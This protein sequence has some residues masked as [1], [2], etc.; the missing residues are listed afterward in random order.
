MFWNGLSNNIL[1]EMRK[2]NRKSL[3]GVVAILTL[4]VAGVA[5]AA[6]VQVDDFNTGSLGEITVSAGTTGATEDAVGSALGDERDIVVT[7][8]SG[9][10]SVSMAVNFLNSAWLAY[11]SGSNVTGKGFVIWDGDDNDAFTS[12]HTMNVD[13]EGGGTN[14]GFHIEV[15]DN[16]RPVRVVIRVYSS[17]TEWSEA[18]FITPGNILFPNHV[19]FFLPFSNF[20]QGAG[21]AAE[22]VFTG[23]SA[24]ELELD[25]TVSTSADISM[26]FLD[27][28]NFRDYGDLPDTFG[29]ATD[30]SHIANGL[31]LGTQVD[32]EA[33]KPA[34]PGT[35]ANV[36]D[37]T[38]ADDEDGV[39][40]TPGVNW[41]VGPGG[42][43]INFSVNGCT[44]APCYLNA[45]MDSNQNNAFDAGEEL[46]IDF[47]VGNSNYT[48]VPVTVPG[49]TTFN[50]AY[51]VRFRICNSPTD[52][53]DQISDVTGGEVEDYYW[54]FGP[55]A[56]TL[57]FLDARPEDNG[58]SALFLSSLVLVLIA[59]LLVF[60]QTRRAALQRE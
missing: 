50:T 38:E 40:R 32:I 56:V 48:A 15:I 26:D 33:S 20:T 13:L 53:A 44:A 24:V 16:D 1:R 28:D 19:D 10:G 47:P 58:S 45:W 14:D 37:N 25:G 41:S 7:H 2:L 46:L 8:V 34:A 23:V 55:T 27:V 59:S 42:G 4:A 39:A 43:Q 17:A 11:T 49:T 6:A 31:R 5:L 18:S 60:R 12:P 3:L 57:S 51:Y 52:C 9:P 21:A 30:A 36:D 22:A 29:A 54:S 35:T